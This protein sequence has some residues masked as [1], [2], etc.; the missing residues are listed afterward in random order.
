MSSP[1]FKNR[2]LAKIHIAKKQLGMNDD[3]Y[4]AVLER[5]TGK[6]SSK[7]LP[8]SKLNDVLNEMKNLGFKTTTATKRIGT[9]KLADDPQAKK[10]RAMWI[11]LRDMGELKDSSEAALLSFVKRMTGVS[12]FEWLDSKQADTIINALRGWIERKGGDPNDY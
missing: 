8:L 11:T 6:T 3:D 5:V 4:R 12:A 10:I 7:G 9:R 2:M 1:D